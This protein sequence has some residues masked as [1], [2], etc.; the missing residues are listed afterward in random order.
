MPVVPSILV[1][2]NS[3]KLTNPFQYR[4]IGSTKVKSQLDSGVYLGITEPVT[5]GT[6]TTW[7]SRMIVVPKKDG[8]P[9]RTEDLQKLNK[10]TYRE[11]H[12]T[13]SP[14]NIVNGIPAGKKKTVLDAWN[15]YHSV[16]LTPEARNATTF[17]TE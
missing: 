5:Q 8:T 11:T 12:H 3:Y 1:Y 14:L 4:I 2:T 9:R 7:C 13:P 15:G 6:P 16:L 10:S 17:I